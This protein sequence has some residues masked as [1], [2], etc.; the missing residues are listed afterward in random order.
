MKIL[1][2]GSINKDL[3]YIVKDFVSPGETISSLNH[4]VYLGG[5]GLNQSVAIARSGSKV[6]HAGNINSSDK[7]II[8]KLKNWGIKT[9]YIRSIKEPTGH[10][11]I[12][13]NK[14]GENSIIIHGGGWKKME[15]FK[16]SNEKF[17]K[18]IYLKFKIS[19]I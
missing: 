11:I 19:R 10:A 16:I 6:F 14:S 1:N 17:K 3:V 4:D 2:F 5:K 18:L 15:K 12:Q 8:E 9:N 7:E 13:V